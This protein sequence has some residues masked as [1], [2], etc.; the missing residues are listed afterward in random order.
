VS[1]TW[2]SPKREPNPL[3]RKGIKARGS[4]EVA[5]LSEEGDGPPPLMFATGKQQAGVVFGRSG[6]V[7][8]SF[9]DSFYRSR[10]KSE[11]SG[12]VSAKAPRR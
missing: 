12:G 1:R 9:R 3:D 8:R 2:L 5:N 10:L 6:A 4:Q 11:E 7:P